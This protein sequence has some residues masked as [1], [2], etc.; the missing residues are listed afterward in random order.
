MLRILFRRLLMILVIVLLHGFTAAASTDLTRIGLEELMQIP[1]YGA[2]KFEPT[3][4]NAPSDI[5]LITADEIQK[6]G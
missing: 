3:P 2:S 4:T 5:T 6:C 1:V